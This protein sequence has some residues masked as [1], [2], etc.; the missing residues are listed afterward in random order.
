MF[1]CRRFQSS[2][3][4]N[5]SETALVLLSLP[6][7]G[8]G[9]DI[10]IQENTRQVD[11]IGGTTWD[12]SLL[13]CELLLRTR[14]ALTECSLLELG[15]GSGLCGICIAADCAVVI[16]TDQE[17]DLV[18]QKLSLNPHN[19]LSAVTLQ[20][21]DE[22][23]ELSDQHWD[24]LFGAEITCLKSQHDSLVDTIDRLADDR[25]IILLTF[26]ESWSNSGDIVYKRS[27][28]ERMTTR[29]FKHKPILDGE[30]SWGKKKVDSPDGLTEFNAI[31]R[32]RKPNEK[33][34][35]T[36]DFSVDQSTEEGETGLV[37]VSLTRHHIEVF[38]RQDLLEADEDTSTSLLLRLLLSDSS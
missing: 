12:G 19:N 9:V 25:T 11:G 32:T 38:F 34:C 18:Q 22:L 28:I 6:T 4:F 37:E 24:V 8:S 7:R 35:A 5:C 29:G 13:L 10:S 17:I 20:W 23:G 33:S 14:A 2:A 31:V 16:T 3:S 1:S 30:V 21:G 27:F 26:D 15:C 36:L